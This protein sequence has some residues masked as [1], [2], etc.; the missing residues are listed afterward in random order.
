MKNQFILFFLLLTVA[1]SEGAPI[2]SDDVLLGVVIGKVRIPV[3]SYPSQKAQW[4]GSLYRGADFIMERDEGAVIKEPLVN[5]RWQR[6]RSGVMTGWIVFTEKTISKTRYLHENLVISSQ[7]G[8]N[9]RDCPDKECRLLRRVNFGEPVRRIMDAFTGNR[10]LW[11]YVKVE[12]DQ[13]YMENSA[14]GPVAYE[15]DYLDKGPVEDMIVESLPSSYEFSRWT[16]MSE[17][18]GFPDDSF[19]L[20]RLKFRG[21]RFIVLAEKTGEANSLRLG[22]I[23]QVF[24]LQAIASGVVYIASNTFDANFVCYRIDGKFF[25]LAEVEYPLPAA[26]LKNSRNGI[27]VYEGVILRIWSFEP[28]YR[29]LV[30]EIPPPDAVCASGESILP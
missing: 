2:R 15:S 1:A 21:Q 19:Y 20:V 16:L 14:L 11:T 18:E 17:A 3:Y 28:R 10:E 25:P 23:A 7:N 26:K 8:A 4:V 13:G 9:L 24:K 30:P 6:I 5:G 29:R 12:G 27:A 22:R